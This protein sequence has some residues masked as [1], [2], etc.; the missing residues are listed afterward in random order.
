MNELI[1]LGILE[2]YQILFVASIAYLILNLFNL[3][4]KFYGNLK[5][6]NKAKYVITI[7][8]KFALLFAFAI[9]LSYII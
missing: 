6:D 9:I 5:L 8:E 3:G 1:R 4:F 2:F 7:G